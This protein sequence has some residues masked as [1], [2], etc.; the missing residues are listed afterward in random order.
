M[1]IYVEET[2]LLNTCIYMSFI[3]II[4]QVFRFKL[5]KIKF[6]IASLLTS[7]FTVLF[8]SLQNILISYSLQLLS[9]LFLLTF[10]LKNLTLKKTIQSLTL[11]IL[12]SNIFTG[13]LSA[14]FVSSS[15]GV[16]L[17]SP[18]PIL[19]FLLLLIFFTYI[20]RKAIQLILLKAK[21]CNNFCNI[22]LTFNN[23]QISTLGYFD[24]GNN[25]TL[26][27]KPVSIIN[28]K[29]FNS[30]TGI[31]LTNFLSKNYDLKSQQYI[32]VS[33]VTGSKK[34]L[35]F[36]L[37]EIKIK[38]HNNIQTIK[39]PSVAISMQLSSKNDYDIILN[40]NYLN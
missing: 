27:N 40:N 30:L 9:T 16:L 37:E 23:K 34:L 38:N 19:L 6:V 1:E 10:S 26:N 20:L 22:E 11:Y 15:S 39:K 32:N 13:L 12:I 36:E 31:S 24:T 5:Y 33:T 14:N 29:L 3:I 17:Y 2:I 8:S 21:N 7:I 28:F 25:L 35:A 4:S 18:L